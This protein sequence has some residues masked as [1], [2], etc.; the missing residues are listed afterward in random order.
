MMAWLAVVL[1]AARESFQAKDLG[2][3]L[4]SSSVRL[5][6]S[7]HCPCLV[8]LTF[9][10]K[11]AHG[12]FWRQ[13]QSER[14]VLA[15]IQVQ[16]RLFRTNVLFFCSQRFNAAVRVYIYNIYIHTYM[17]PRIG[18]VFR[19]LSGSRGFCELEPGCGDRST[20]TLFNFRNCG[21]PTCMLHCSQAV[22]R[23]LSFFQ[24]PARCGAASVTFVTSG[25]LS[26]RVFAWK[27][28]WPPWPRYACRKFRLMD[29]H[30]T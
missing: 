1:A 25:N 10:S 29:L 7:I 5:F 4:V 14:G 2:A 30:L 22:E 17:L 9:G 23:S 26:T 11:L 21:P 6:M 12:H 20:S 19:A 16:S 28:T 13:P 24:R 8:G 27:W 18:L 15:R 3:K